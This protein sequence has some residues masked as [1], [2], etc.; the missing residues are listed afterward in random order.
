[1]KAFKI[2]LLTMLPVSFVFG[3]LLAL[4]RTAPVAASPIE[5]T[6]VEINEAAV[7]LDYLSRKD[8]Y[9]HKENMEEALSVSAT[10][11]FENLG[12]K[13]YHIVDLRNPEDFYPMHIPGAV[14]VEQALVYDYLKSIPLDYIHKVVLVCYAGQR[15]SY[16][17]GLIRLLGIEDVYFLRWGMSAWQYPVARDNWLRNIS[18]NFAGRMVTPT[19]A[20]AGG[21]EL[22]MI[23]TFKT[24]GQ[25]ILQARVIELLQEEF[26]NA[27]VRADEIMADPLQFQIVV[28]DPKITN[29][30]VLAP[31]GSIMLPLFGRAEA[32]SNL[33]YLLPFNPIV[34]ASVNGQTGGLVAAFLRTLGYDARFLSSGL[35]TLTFNSLRD[36]GLTVF[37]QGEI[38]NFG[39]TKSTPPVKAEAPQRAVAGC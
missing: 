9:L 38:K 25:E 24:T 37:S 21:N 6:P 22:P 15:A 11:V 34:V 30:D 13:K 4:E 7:L 35:S 28:S 1:M 16:V 2:A 12:N 18:N 17:T 26:V 39:T 19:E 31:E 14:L 27:R 5:E 3:G 20:S 32:T 33:S 8:L 10:E 23:F 29:V 36:T